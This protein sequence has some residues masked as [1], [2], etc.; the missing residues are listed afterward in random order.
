MGVLA[1]VAREKGGGLISAYRS[2][3]ITTN[4]L[5]F[6]KLSTALNLWYDK[7]SESANCNNRFGGCCRKTEHCVLP[8]H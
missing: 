8:D 4:T 3:A 6:K 5:G 2:L 1:G 7:S